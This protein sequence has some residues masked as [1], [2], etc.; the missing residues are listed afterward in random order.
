[1]V[2]NK[3]QTVVEEL[4]LSLIPYSKQSYNLA[5]NPHA[6]F[7][8]LDRLSKHSR[9]SIEIA[10]CRAKKNKLISINNDKIEISLKGMQIIQPFIAKKLSNDAKLMIIFDIPEDL[11]GK[12]QRLRNLLKKLNFEQIQLSVWLTNMDH[13]K[14]VLES[15][16]E[17]EIEQYVQLYEADRIISLA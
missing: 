3:S 15:I 14:I 17:L 5:F 12:R 6:F 7:N 8:E 10:Y 4:L 9:N 2:R 1:M 11:A 16:I 13:R